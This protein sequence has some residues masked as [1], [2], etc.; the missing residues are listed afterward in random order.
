[1][2]RLNDT[3]AGYLICLACY[4]LLY[5][6]L[7]IFSFLALTGDILYPPQNNSWFLRLSVFQ[8]CVGSVAEMLSR[9]LGFLVWGVMVV[10]VCS[11]VCL[12]VFYLPG[13][14]TNL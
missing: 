6:A 3:S 1:M 11:I 13:V 8:P 12:F 10:F 5:S 4:G 7:L 2:F 14:S 9:S